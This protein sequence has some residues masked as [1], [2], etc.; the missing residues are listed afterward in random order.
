MELVDEIQQ[1]KTEKNAI[2]LAHNYQ[3]PEIYEVADYIGDSLELT[4]KAMQ[5]SAKLIVFCGVHFMA[6]TAAI[7][8]PDKKVLLPVVDAGCPLADQIKP[9]DLHSLLN[10]HPEAAIVSYI[11]SPANVKALSD[12]VCTSANAIDIVNSVDSNDVIFLPDHNLGQWVAMHTNKN[13]KLWRG[14]CYAHTKIST[15]AVKQAKFNYPNAKLVAHPE[16]DMEILKIADKVCGTGGMIKYAKE[17]D[18]QEFL[19]ATECG[20]VER[21]KKEVPGKRFYA[22]GNVCFNMKKTGL[23]DVK[24][25]LLKQEHHIVVPEHIAKKAKIA[26][27][28]MM[29]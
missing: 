12:I 3:R 6:E 11:N 2:I 16:C 7:L 18:A 21:L 5:S 28:R 9:D 13:I 8:N 27:M 15:K 14:N 19:I 23:S 29:R 10:K 26:L 20:M 22:F 25:A 1:L 4:K 24:N 17:N